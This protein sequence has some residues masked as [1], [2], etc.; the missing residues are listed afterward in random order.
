MYRV[1]VYE[2]VIRSRTKDSRF[3]ARAFQASLGIKVYKSM[4]LLSEA[5]IITGDVI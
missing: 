4:E 3:S 1:N 5:N 2:N